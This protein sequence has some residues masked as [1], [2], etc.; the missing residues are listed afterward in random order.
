LEAQHRPN[1][2]LQALGQLLFVHVADKHTS[3]RLDESLIRLEDVVGGCE[4]LYRTP[5]PLSYTRHTSRLLLVWLAYMPLAVWGEVGA[6]ALLVAPLLVV[7]LF[8]IDEIG[9]ELEEPFSLLPLDILCEAVETQTQELVEV[10][11]VVRS[12][13]GTGDGGAQA[14]LNGS[15]WAHLRK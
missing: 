5:I 9:V 6:A 11:G 8:G 12:L 15:K 13:V 2:C 3:L 10:N 14:W 7:A 1:F 4:R